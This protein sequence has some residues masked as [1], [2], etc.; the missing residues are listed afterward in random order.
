MSVER[1]LI[2]GGET[3]EMVFVDSRGDKIHGTV[4]KDEVGQ[5]THVLQQGQTKV[6]INFTVTHSSGSYWTTKH[7][8]KVVFLPTTRVRI[9]EVLPYNMTGLEP[10]NYRAML[11]AKLLKCP[12]LKL[13]LSMARTPRRSLWN[14]VILNVVGQVV[15]VSHIE[16][17]SVNGKDTQ[18][19]SVE[20]CDTEDER[21]PL[22]L[23]GK[24]AEDISDAVQLRSENIVICVLRFGKIK[25]WKGNF[26]MF[27]ERSVSN[28]YNVSDVSVNPENMAEVQAF[29]RLLPKDD[30]KL[31]IVDSKPLALANGGEVYCNGHNCGY[32][33]H[34]VVLDNT[35]DCKF[36]FFDNL[37]LQLLHQP[38]IE[39]TGPITDEGSE[40]M[41]SGTF[42]TQSDAPEGS[43]M[44]QGGSSGSTDLTPAKRTRTP[45]IN[46]EEAFDQNSGSE[47]MLSGT[48]STQSDAPEGSLMIQGGSSGST[49][50]TPAKRTRTPII[51][52]E[53]AFDQNSVT[54]MACTIK[55]KK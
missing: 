33:L 29:I 40:N 14:C 23:W 44:I 47:N 48:F 11:S 3:I 9:C 15:E 49:D 22:V 42:S 26:V 32:K 18:K 46:L 24:F 12:T 10:V 21:L 16:V 35:N 52:L 36:L 41:L 55:A 38:C 6:Q 4:K 43:L 28:A 17:V 25:V 8:Y 37:A 51:N 13:C 19:I 1:T 2:W 31:S 34:L 27:Y 5:F 50:L 39:L 7:P 45:I 53:E 30:L 20:L 54:K